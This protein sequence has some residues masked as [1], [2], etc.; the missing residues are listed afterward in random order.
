MSSTDWSE[1]FLLLPSIDNDNL[2]MVELVEASDNSNPDNDRLTALVKD[3]DTVIMSYV[4][5]SDTILQRNPPPPSH[6]ETWWHAFEQGSFI[7]RLEWVW[8]FCLSRSKIT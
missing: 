2:V 1:F 4:H 5:P 7:C 8:S 6:D 3:P